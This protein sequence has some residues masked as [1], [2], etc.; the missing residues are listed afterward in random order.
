MT[1]ADELFQ[2]A[3]ALNELA[4]RGTSTLTEVELDTALLGRSAVLDLLATVNGDVAGI[5][6]NHRPTVDLL[7]RHPVAAFGQALA[8]YRRI[9]PHDL[10]RDLD[11]T[12]LRRRNRLDPLPAEHGVE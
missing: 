3:R 9:A 11:R 12:P 1:Y 2:T 7:A 4:V 10:R 5:R 6:S 8:N